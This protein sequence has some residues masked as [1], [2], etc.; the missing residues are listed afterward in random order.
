MKG[1]NI[2][3]KIEANQIRQLLKKKIE[4]GNEKK[5]R[6]QL[7]KIGFYISNFGFS[8]DGFSP[9]DFEALVASGKIQVIDQEKN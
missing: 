2:F 3:N 7:R 8:K 6:D 5:Y 9:E 4:S 1:K